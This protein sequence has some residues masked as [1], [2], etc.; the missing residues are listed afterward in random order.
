LAGE[1]ISAWGRT[2]TRILR[3]SVSSA[4][5]GTSLEI[6]AVN[7][8]ECTVLHVSGG[9]GRDAAPAALLQDKIA[10]LNVGS[11]PRVV[12][13]LGGVTAWDTSGVGAVVGAV[14]RVVTAGG[15]LVIAATPADLLERFQRQGLE[16]RLELRETVEQAVSAF[17][18]PE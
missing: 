3:S 14:K 15:R 1:A 7:H 16:E 12:L 5:T 17:R 13:D 11:P 18:T 2:E 9:L 4:R 8:G 6:Q 10:S